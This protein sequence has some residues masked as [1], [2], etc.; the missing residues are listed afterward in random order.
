[1]KDILLGG[2]LGGIAMLI[3][4]LVGLS[5]TWSVTNSVP[6]PL[7]DQEVVL[8][9]LKERINEPGVYT[10]PYATGPEMATDSTYLNEPFFEI[11]YSGLTHSTV[12]GF[13]SFGSTGFLLAPLMAALLLSMAAPHRVSSYGK[14]LLFV[15][16]LGLTTVFFAD[17]LGAIK[18]ERSLSYML[19]ASGCNLIGWLFAGLV[20]AWRVKPTTR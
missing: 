16:L 4:L 5:L 20:I 11:Q 17:F 13:K 10:V 7:P 1:M 18:E 8:E 3:G 19:A 6:R 14:R 2:V 9:L 15:L 12:S